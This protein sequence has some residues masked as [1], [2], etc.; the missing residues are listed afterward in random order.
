MGDLILCSSGVSCKSVD[1]ELTSSVQM[2]GAI[3]N[4]QLVQDHVE[5]GLQ[6]FAYSVFDM[7]MHF[8]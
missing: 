5:L 2:S 6:R 3:G 1:D 8:A 7:S 4:K